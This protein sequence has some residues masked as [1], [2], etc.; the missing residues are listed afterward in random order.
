MYPIVIGRSIAAACAILFSLICIVGNAS[1]QVSVTTYHYDN[2]RTGWNSGETTLSQ[3]AVAK[4][5]FGLLQAISLDDQVDAQP[6]VVPNVTI[7][8]QLHT[9]VYVAT[10]SNTVYA[11]DSSSGQVLLQTNLGA[12]VPYTDLPG[13]CNN[14]G[15]NVGINSTPV[16]DT[17]RGIL[18]VIAYTW[19]NNAPVFRIHALSL[20]TLSDS[21][22]PVVVTASGTLSDGSTYDFNP[23]VSRQRAALLL[24]NDTVYAGFA[25]FCDYAADQSRGWVLGW[26]AGTLAPLASNELTNKRSTAPDTFYLSSIWMSGYGLA[27][28]AAGSVY[29]VTGNSDY[30]GNTYNSVT[31]IAESAAAM[32]PDLSTVRGLFTPSNHAYLDRVDG[33]YGSGGLMLLPPQSGNHPNLAAAAGKDG[34]L[35]LLDADK[36]TMLGAY[37]I[38]AC[39]CG[40]SYCQGSNGAGRIVSS[41]N[42]AIGVWELKGKK[43]KLVLK[44]QA[45]G[46]ADGQFPGFFYQRLVERHSIG[47]SRYMGGGKAHRQQSGQC[48]SLRRQRR[49]RA[50]ALQQRC[51]AMAEYGWRFEHC[52]GCRQWPRLCRFKPDADSFWDWRRQ[53]FRFSAPDPACGYASATAAWPSRGVWHGARGE[54]CLGH[55]LAP[56]WWSVAGR[57]HGRDEELPLCRATGWPWHCR[58]RGIHASGT[59]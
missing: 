48:R 39:W 41:G 43:P 9:V 37:Q 24:S 47:N 3:K 50:Y 14:N 7:G 2:F 49:Q 18:Y 1:A 5:S 21:L 16:I 59:S 25:S 13:G 4:K 58:A 51:R 17:G 30:S 44:K 19:E 54:R 10:E 34:N 52:S 23:A 28:N 32:S 15:P 22:S 45:D 6:L 31:N 42:T 56:E 11:I 33:D 27:A 20:S 8:G 38:G 57:C 35:Y 55:P 53:G 36:M 29:F 46:I 40:P 26:Q 12:P